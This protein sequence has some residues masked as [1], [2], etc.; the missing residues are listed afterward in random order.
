MGRSITPAATGAARLQLAE[1]LLNSVK[2]MSRGEQLQAMRDLA[3][4][5][6]TAIKRN[7]N[8]S[9]GAGLDLLLYLI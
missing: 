7:Q 9:L 5:K 4:K 2:Q 8:P 3:S 1:G 6:D